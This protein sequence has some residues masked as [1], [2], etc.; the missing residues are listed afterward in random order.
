[1]NSR[2]NNL[3]DDAKI[4]FECL[5]LKLAEVTE[6]V[7]LSIM[8]KT[9]LFSL[10]FVF[11]RVG[12]LPCLL[13]HL[14]SLASLLKQEDVG[15]E[16]SMIPSVKGDFSAVVTSCLHHTRSYTYLTRPVSSGAQSCLCVRTCFSIEFLFVLTNIIHKFFIC[17]KSGPKEPQTGFYH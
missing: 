14:F 3:G 2:Y 5:S 16:A 15:Q 17:L 10:F 1:M 8:E 11:L 13:V 6:E 9:H 12:S 4:Y 7:K